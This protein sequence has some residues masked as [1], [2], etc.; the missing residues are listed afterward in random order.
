MEVLVGSS[1]N[2]SPL[3]SGMTNQGEAAPGT[4]AEWEEIADGNGQK[5]Y[6]CPSTGETTWDKPLGFC[7]AACE[8]VSISGH[9]FTSLDAVARL[10]QW[11]VA[12][13]VTTLRL[14]DNCI[15]LERSTFF[16]RLGRII[17]PD[18]QKG[19]STFQ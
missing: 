1:A 4:S 19:R 14:Q 17:C 15:L 5:Y 2:A 6:Y 9:A 3:I 12:A 7:S 10:L 8:V 13:T 11:R 18:A 16:A